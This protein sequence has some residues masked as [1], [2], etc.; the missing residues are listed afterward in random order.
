MTVLSWLHLTDLH[1][2][3]TDQDWLWPT[4][5][6]ALFDDLAKVH[7]HAGPWD[8]VLFT[9][10]L[11]QRG[12]VDIP[13]GPLLATVLNGGSPRL[14][15][16]ARRL[17]LLPAACSDEVIAGLAI[18]EIDVC[19]LSGEGDGGIRGSAGRCRD[20]TSATSQEN[21]TSMSTTW[22][23]ACS[24]WRPS[25]PSCSKRVSCRSCEPWVPG[26][27]REPPP[28]NRGESRPPDILRRR[29]VRTSGRHRGRAGRRLPHAGAT[30]ARI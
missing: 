15:A 2:G 4:T 17:G 27:I 13:L 22:C 25:G 19:I 20:L 16:T 24:G 14:L 5:R 6:R 18:D 8:L 9:G 12:S 7:D 1:Q 23:G 3:M 11:T 29:N 26:T 10:D 30:S 28:R 21:R